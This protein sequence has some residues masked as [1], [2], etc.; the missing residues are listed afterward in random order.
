ML[1]SIGYTPEDK[2]ELHPQHIYKVCLDRFGEVESG[3]KRSGKPSRRQNKGQ[4]LREQIKALQS[5][6][7]EAPEEE[8][9]GIQVLQRESIKKLRLLKRAES[10]RLKRKKNKENTDSFYKQPFNFARK[11][12][13]PEIKGSL[14]STKEEVEE[15]LRKTHSDSSRDEELGEVEGLYE[16]P[17][18]EHEFESAPPTLKEFQ[19]VLKKA[20]MKSAAGPN[21]VPYRVYKKCPGVA[22]LLWYYIR[23][24]WK[25]NKISDT[26]RRA[27]GVLIP[28]EDQARSIEKF[29]TISLLNTEGKIFW[30]LKS[31]RMTSFIMKNHYID[32][33]IQKG[34][35]PGVSGCLEHT[36]ILSHMIMEAKKGKLNL[37][38]TWLDI[39]N[40]YGSIAHLLLEVTLSRAHIPIEVRELVRSYYENVEIRFTT[41]SFTTSWQR[42]E[43]G[44]ITGCTLSVI[45]FALSMTMLLASTK[46]ETKGPVTASGQ[47]QQNARLYMDDVSTTAGTI[48][49]TH[50][51]LE[52]ISRFFTWGRLTVKPGKCRVLVLEKG[53]PR[54][55]PVLWNNQALTSIIQ[56]PIKYLG[57]EYNYSLSDKQQIEQTIRRLCEGIKKI[58]KTFISGRNKAWILQHM[59]IPRLMWPLTIYSFPQTKVEEIERKIS[60]SLKKWLGIPKS[61]S[62]ALLYGRS[63]VIQLPY[64]SIVEEVKVARVRTQVMLDTSKDACI[65]NANISLDAGRKW[66]VSE[67]LEVAKS[68]LRLQEIAG[69]A[70]KGR[71]GL[72]LNHRQYYSKSTQV[73]KKKLIVQKV[74]EAEEEQRL[75]KVAGLSKQGSSL[76]WG[77]QQ[78]VIKDAEMRTTP[79]ALFQFTIKAVYD[80]L[81]TPQNKNL[82]FNTDQYSCYLC[83]GMGTLNHILSGCPVALEQGRYKW[84]HDKVLREL[85]DWVDQKKKIINNMPWKK[86]SWIKFKKAG[87]KGKVAPSVTEESVLRFSRDWKIQVDLPGAPL[88]IPCHIA[89]TMQRPDIILTSEALKQL[90]IIELTCPT[91]DRVEISSELKRTKYED[92]LAKAAKMKGWN[93]LIYTV[94]VGCRGF[95]ARSMV[96]MLKEIGYKGRQ[97]KMILRKLGTIAE[98]CSLTIWKSSHFRSWGEA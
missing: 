56:K 49:Q 48:T 74:R 16:Y 45:L 31:D 71:E 23:G 28:K 98:E 8:K 15:F 47:Q 65:K 1:R 73:E 63:A 35:I 67:S 17:D 75:V 10:I 11:V 70:N 13:D 91:E 84:R 38:A 87:E 7:K 33:S 18:P 64:S 85:G 62:T 61:L 96:K 51:L 95:P 24:L 27:D 80:L 83:G 86:K 90:I 46:K 89:A 94:E 26:W 32:E 20:R 19:S 4:K 81:P 40:A 88:S 34:G 29:R 2:A 72:G 12:L 22:K 57:K 42:V 14:E 79:D 25:R 50:H 93:T 6:W 5:A 82:W 92:D 36:A 55:Q 69:I 3:K 37:V 52:E 97:K 41:K 78:R 30:K 58:E 44:I 60:A 39:A 43:K 21:G 53:V 54:D 68:K 76:T 77:V 59:L 66:K 9:E